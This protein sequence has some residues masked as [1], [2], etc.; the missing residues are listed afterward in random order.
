M[1]LNKACSSGGA[2]GN[3]VARVIKIFV[4]NENFNC[5]NNNNNIG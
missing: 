1:W 4:E 5:F 3:E 2:V